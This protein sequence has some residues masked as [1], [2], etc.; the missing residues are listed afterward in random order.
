METADKIDMLMYI[1]EYIYTYVYILLKLGGARTAM[2]IPYSRT[3][4]EP[5]NHEF[6]GLYSVTI[7]FHDRVPNI[8]QH[9][10]GWV[11]EV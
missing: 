9:P 4:K 5:Y 7:S 2:Y 6:I 11:K 10:W 8:W 1:Y 3:F